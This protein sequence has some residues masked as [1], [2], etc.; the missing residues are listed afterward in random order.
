MN[1][2]MPDGG[3]HECES[4]ESI[5]I[6]TLPEGTQEM[7]RGHLRQWCH[8]E[9]NFCVYMSADKMYQENSGDPLF[10]E[11]RPPTTFLN[12]FL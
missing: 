11:S 8:K 9:P 12:V 4:G 10:S 7:G 1:T 6:H 3:M 5:F 2:W